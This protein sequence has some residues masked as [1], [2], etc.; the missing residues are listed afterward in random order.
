MNK[1]SA[2]P[3]KLWAPSEQRIKAARITAFTQWLARTRG[4]KFAGY[5]PLWQWSI[6]DLEGFWSAVWEYFDIPARRTYRRVL[7]NDRMP[8]AVWFEGAELN[9]VEQVFRARD[10]DASAIQFHSEAAG[11]GTLSWKELETQVAALA[12][13]LRE[14]GVGRGDRVAAILPNVPHSVIAFLAVASVGAVWTLCAPDMGPQSI[15]DRFQ[16]IEPIVMIACD[17]YRYGGKDYD[18]RELLGQVLAKLTT[19]RRVILVPLISDS[20]FGGSS[21]R[22]RTILWREAVSEPQKLQTDSVPFDHPLWILYSSGTTG[23]PKAI[24][25]SHGGILLNGLVAMGLHT[26]LGPG[27]V[28]FWLASTA[29]VIWNAQVKALTVGATLFL[30]DG[31]V[32]G[33]GSSPDWGHVWELVGRYRITLFGAGAAYFAGCLKAGL[34][35]KARAD[36]FALRALSSTG[37]PLSVDCYRWIYRDVKPDVWLANISGGTDIAGAFLGSNPTLPVYLGEMQCRSL[38][39]SV[40]AFDDAGRPTMDEIGELVCTRPIPSMPIRLWNDPEGRRYLES[41]FGTFTGKNGERIWRQGDWLR[42]TARPESV[43]SVIFGRSDATVNRQGVRMG[44]AEFYRVVE[45]FPEVL[46]SLVV[47][48]E[49]LGRAPY[50][51]LF[52]VL[53]AGCDLTP[54]LDQRIRGALRDGLSPRHVPNEVLQVPAIPRT[55]TGKKLE[56]PVRRL[57]LG[58]RIESVVSRDSLAN[59]ESLDWY[60][61]FAKSFAPPAGEQ[62][63]TQPA[64][65]VC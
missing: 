34:I 21:A 26:D 2:L 54:E 27:D 56:V 14:F 44:T 39:A 9:F 19:V 15:T 24:V 6:T 4:L 17:G 50:L 10:P 32:T 3:E 20:P 16:Q 52:I 45:A 63:S 58:Q 29:W 62:A 35:P 38:G 53:R 36:L 42:L 40:F 61:E 11:T 13:T 33:S 22:L 60:M 49:Y 30:F 1:P 41:Y 57:L 28:L 64:G 43:T 59:P 8:G 51:G 12:G 46:D 23:L 37:S 5:E 7:G 31:A 18:R 65:G 47:D 55:L 25:H 48:L